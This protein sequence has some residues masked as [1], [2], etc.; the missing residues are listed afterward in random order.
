MITLKQ[1]MEV[2]NFRITEGTDY[3]WDCYGQSAYCMDSWNG[4][5]EGHSL[6]IIFDT[7]TQVVYEVQAHD[8]QRNRAYRL[9][10]PDFKLDHSEEA[11]NRGVDFNEAWDEVRYIDLETDDDF[12]EKAFAIVNDQEYDT[13]VEVPL[14]LDDDVLYKLMT[15]AH[16]QDITL[17]QLFENVLR[18]EID[19]IKS[20]PEVEPLKG[21]MKKGKK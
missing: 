3:C 11:A 1:F 15:L 9:I 19:R 7:Q 17:N 21:K 8:Y 6:C 14:T 18:E 5:L 4:N 20:T 10:N 16:E 2:A 13:R 12:L